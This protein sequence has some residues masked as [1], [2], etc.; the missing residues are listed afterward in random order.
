MLLAGLPPFHDSSEPRLLR[1]I[2]KGQ[3]SFQDA[4]WQEVG[5]WRWVL[6]W[7]VGRP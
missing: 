1:K 4:V 2:M 7:E 5:G 3:F 6:G